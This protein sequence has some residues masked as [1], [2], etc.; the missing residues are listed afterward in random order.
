[1]PSLFD[2][3]GAYYATFSDASRRPRQR[4]HSLKTRSRR[5]AERL[6]ARLAEAYDLGLWDPW[7]G[8]PD[9]VLHPD[10]V[11]D[12]KRL[13]EAVAAY[14]VHAR[15]A[16]RPITYRT[17]R[18]VVD[19]FAAHVGPGI[20]LQRVTARDVASFVASGDVAASTQGTRLVGVKALFTHCVREGWVGAS[21]AH[22]VPRPTPP[23]RFPRAVTDE[24]LEAVLAAIPEHRAW[25]RPAFLFAALTGLRVSELARL[26]WDDVDADGRLLRIERQKNG[27]AETQPI[28]RSALAVLSGLPRR[29]PH[30]F[31]SPRERRPTRSVGSFA[32]LLNTAFRE[33]REAA[34][35]ARPITPHGLRHRYCTKLAEAGASAFTI[36]A[37]ARHADVKTSQRYVDISNRRLRQ[38]LDEVFG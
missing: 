23:P 38:A 31:G 34:G 22:A 11:E 32:N 7:T 18:G 28:S 16:L 35:V 21:P 8:A 6:L 12:P 29:G 1:M 27:K 36:A 2:R 19:R 30:V 5:T 17:R 9:D 15:R 4:R 24:E 26:R 37:A 25:T 33:A 13:G 10:R 14:L 3:H 20:Y